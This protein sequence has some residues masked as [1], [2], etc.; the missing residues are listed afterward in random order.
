MAIKIQKVS[1]YYARVKDKPGE[2]YRFLAVLGDAGVNLLAFDAI[3]MGPDNTQL[4]IFPEHPDLLMQTCRGAGI[5]LEGP[6]QALLIQGDDRLG[7]FAEIHHVLADADINVF[8]SKGVTDG[9]GGYGYIIWV[10]PDD[11]D[12]AASALGIR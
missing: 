3:P 4:V 2:A 6:H 12:R 9:R 11:V 5:D 8:A 7:A 1:Y 10:K